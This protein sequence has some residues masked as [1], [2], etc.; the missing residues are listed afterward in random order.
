MPGFLIR[1]LDQLRKRPLFW[2][3]WVAC[4]IG[5]TIFLTLVGMPIP[6]ALVIFALAIVSILFSRAKYLPILIIILLAIMPWTS[7]DQYWL[8]VLITVGIYIMLALGLNVIIGFTGM[9]D[10]GYIAFFG[11]GAYT[12]ALLTTHFHLSWWLCLLA[13]I[14]VA[15]IFGVL[16]GLPTLRLS[17][18]YLAIVTLGFGEIAR[19]TF[20]NWVGLT[21]GPMGIR[22]I[23]PP[24]VFGFSFGFSAQWGYRL[25]YYLI[26]V[27][28]GLTV[29]TIT[30]LRNSRL[31]RAWVAIRE[32]ETAAQTMGVNLSWNKT[33][34]YAVGAAY[35]GAA[36]AFFAS[37]NMFV[38]PNSFTFFE[39]A[40]VLCMVVIGG[41]GSIPG[42]IIGASIL[43][44]FPE[45]LRFMSEYRYLIFGLIMVIMVIFKPRGILPER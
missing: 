26:L 20:A 16:R 10:L 19:M 1:R 6:Y 24:S 41:I 37:F 11:I 31:G 14:V 32:D 9:L 33:L 36:G 12:T 3:I 42:V 29:L 2:G 5:I 23:T 15:A 17:G 38:S 13:S 45:V 28:L 8:R 18:D 22:D 4:L 39:S 7:Q 21:G 43:A 40:I 34:A 44:A 27:L 35:G 25:Y 30:N